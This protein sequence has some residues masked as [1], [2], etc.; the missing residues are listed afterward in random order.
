MNNRLLENEQLCIRSCEVWSLRQTGIVGGSYAGVRCAT[1][2]L[3]D[4]N[5]V[6][7]RGACWLSSTE[8]KG[9]R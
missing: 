5:P 6:L 2:T 1:V 7:D 8:R 9:R 3:C 4:F